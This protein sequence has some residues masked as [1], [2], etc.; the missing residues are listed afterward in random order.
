MGYLDLDLRF[1]RLHEKEDTE[2]QHIFN[3]EVFVK[4]F[5]D[6]PPKSTEV[7]V[8]VL[9]QCNSGLVLGPVSMDLIDDVLVG[10]LE[11]GKYKI[12][13]AVYLGPP[14]PRSKHS[15]MRRNP[16][17]AGLKLASTST[18][19]EMIVLRFT[20]D[21]ALLTV[22]AK[23]DVAT[24]LWASQSQG[25]FFYGKARRVFGGTTRDLEM[26]QTSGPGL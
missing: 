1:E 24:G 9:R 3:C 8:L 19:H 11:S 14:V 7:I 26:F 10:I 15:T 25:Q 6:T 17:G 20:N 2:S 13:K 22:P 21:I 16:I 4:W 18:R 23:Y 5:Q 12:L